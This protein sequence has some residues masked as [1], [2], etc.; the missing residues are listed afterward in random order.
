MLSLLSL[1]LLHRFCSKGCLQDAIDRGW[2]RHGPS[3]PVSLAKVVVT[4]AEVAAGMAALH[5]ADIVH[6]DLSPY[7]VLLSE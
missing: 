4:A 2:L 1:P 7:N 5:K 3:G 6:G